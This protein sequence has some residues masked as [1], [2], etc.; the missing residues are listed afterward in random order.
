MPA[1]TSNTYYS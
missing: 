1:V